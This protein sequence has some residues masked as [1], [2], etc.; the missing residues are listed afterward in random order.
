MPHLPMYVVN[1]LVFI[2][3]VVTML[4]IYILKLFCVEIFFIICSKWQIFVRHKKMRRPAWKATILTT[5]PPTPLFQDVACKKKKKIQYCFLESTK[6]YSQST[7]TLF[8]TFVDYK[9]DIL[10]KSWLSFKKVVQK[11]LDPFYLQNC[12]F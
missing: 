2:S 5:I 11:V 7:P 8:L 10:R 4:I 6:P 1:L 12:S 3:M 9:I